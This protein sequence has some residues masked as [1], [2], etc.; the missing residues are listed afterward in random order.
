[1]AETPIIDGE[2]VAA[3][4]SADART[5]RLEEEHVLRRDLRVE[6]DN[7]VAILI[8]M[9]VLFERMERVVVLSLMRLVLG[10]E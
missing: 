10:A 5:M 2:E 7:W 1:M 8:M 9:V 6:L 4:A 3:R